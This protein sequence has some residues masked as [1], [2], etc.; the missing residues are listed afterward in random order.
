MT[1]IKFRWKTTEA[2]H[3]FDPVA[4]GRA[5]A[6]GLVAW[7]KGNMGGYAWYLYRDDG[8]RETRIASGLVI[9]PETAMAVVE[10]E[11]GIRFGEPES[12]INI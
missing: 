11:A 7:V 1:P 3:P 2:K 8:I 6:R 12:L 5:R 10:R 4:I 9:D